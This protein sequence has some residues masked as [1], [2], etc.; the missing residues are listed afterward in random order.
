MEIERFKPCSDNDKSRACKIQIII[1]YKTVKVSVII[2]A[3]AN[4]SQKISR[5][6]LFLKIRRS[7]TQG[8]PK[9]VFCKISVRRSKYCLEL[10]IT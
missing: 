9:T 7:L 4:M 10:S 1:R 2:R 6:H 3:E 5:D 8:H